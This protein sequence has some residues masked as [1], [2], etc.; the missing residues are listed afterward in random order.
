M[1]HMQIFFLCLILGAAHGIIPLILD[2]AEWI[3]SNPFKKERFTP[4]GGK[5]YTQ[6]Y[7]TPFSLK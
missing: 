3:I 2:L 1:N 7:T 5:N 6:I 4:G